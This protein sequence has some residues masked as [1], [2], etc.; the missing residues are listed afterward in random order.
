MREIL[1]RGK[2][3]KTGEWVYGHY[4]TRT[5]QNGELIHY[6]TALDHWGNY[7]VIPESVGQWTGLKDKNKVRIFEG[8]IV[9]Y[10]HSE[11]SS[12]YTGE[13]YYN[14]NSSSFYIKTGDLS[15]FA[16]L[17]QQKII[18]VTGNI[19]NKSNQ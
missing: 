4:F 6:I 12:E 11:N 17:G 1:F 10:Q 8:D 5:I 15:G 9:K 3:I 2:R 19:H 16:L 14:N 13:I 7:H 18:E